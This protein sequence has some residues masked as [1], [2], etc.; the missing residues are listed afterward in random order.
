M[1]DDST[2]VAACCFPSSAAK[3]VDFRVVRREATALDGRLPPSPSEEMGLSEKEHSLLRRL[4]PPGFTKL[5]E[6]KENGV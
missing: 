4:L 5:N 2:S 6:M 1:K 3:V